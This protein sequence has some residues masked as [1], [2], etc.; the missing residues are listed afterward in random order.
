MEQSHGTHRHYIR[1]GAKGCIF[2]LRRAWTFT[3]PGPGGYTKSGDEYEANLR[4]DDPRIALEKA[5]EILGNPEAKIPFE[6]G[7][8]GVQRGGDAT[9]R[10]NFGKYEGA[11]MEEVPAEYLVWA[12][13]QYE[14]RLGKKRSEYIR[15]LPSFHDEVE[16]QAQKVQERVERQERWEREKEE[17][18][19]VSQWVGAIG[20]RITVDVEVL[21][22]RDSE[23][24]WGMTAFVLLADANGNKFLSSGSGGANFDIWRAHEEWFESCFDEDEVKLPV[25]QRP[26]KPRLTLTGTVKDHS[27]R[28]GEKG[29][30]LQRLAIDQWAD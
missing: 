19:K 22:A 4:T 30:W 17:A 14:K 18:M 16:R 28:E 21:Y 3:V 8:S 10:I 24:H 26:A 11:L 20:D 1:A 13:G 7:A 5:R 15:S 23:N 29:T 9:H 27:E 25:D 6:S 2:T 12:L